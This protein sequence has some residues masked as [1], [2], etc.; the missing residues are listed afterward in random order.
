[1]STGWVAEKFDKIPKAFLIHINAEF[2]DI[3]RVVYDI[4]M[5]ELPPKRRIPK[6]LQLRA[7]KILLQLSVFQG[8]VA[9]LIT[10]MDFMGYEDDHVQPKPEEKPE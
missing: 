4:S 6:Y 5:H 10:K 9:D 3:A 2:Q 7:Y 1:M 8:N